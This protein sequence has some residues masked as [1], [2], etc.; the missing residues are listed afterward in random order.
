MSMIQTTNELKS[1]AS[2]RYHDINIGSVN[3]KLKGNVH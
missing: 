1:H 3:L 2:F